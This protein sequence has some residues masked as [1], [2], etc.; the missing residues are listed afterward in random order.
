[1]KLRTFRS[2]PQD[3]VA[4]GREPGTAFAPQF[5]RTAALYL[6][7]FAE[8]GIPADEVR[9]IAERSRRAVGARRRRRRTEILAAAPPRT[10]GECSTAVHV[11]PDVPAETP[12][13]DRPVVE[14]E[15]RACRPRSALRTPRARA[16]HARRRR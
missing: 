11:V 13:S 15:V 3:A 14:G 8:L 16:L 10:E 6:A 1:M 7:H 2:T 12:A 5:R 9:A 4:R